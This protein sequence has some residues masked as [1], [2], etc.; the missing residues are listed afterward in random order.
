MTK[1]KMLT[2]TDLHCIESLYR[3]LAQVVSKHRPHIVALVGD[4]LDA[5]GSSHKQ[6]TSAG[7]ARALA[8][9]HCEHVLFVRGNHED[10]NWWGFEKAWANTGRKLNALHGEA[11]VWGP[12]VIVGFPCDLGDETAFVGNRN[13]LAHPPHQWLSALLRRHGAAMRTLWLMHEPPFG[14]PLT[15]KSG[16]VSGNQLWNQVIEQFSP[17]LVISGHDHDTP[18]RTGQWYARVARSHVVNVGQTSSGALHYCVIDAQFPKN[19]KC[20]PSS[21]QIT[22]FPHGKRIILPEIASATKGS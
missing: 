7:C 13:S 9:L 15:V 20:L 1:L 11:F 14:T 12:L 22:G 6:L 17:W 5:L 3:Q 8:G 10:E 4:F 2:A 21:L 18:I 16:P 19:T